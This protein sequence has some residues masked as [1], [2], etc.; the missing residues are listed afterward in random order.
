MSWKMES[1]L[2]MP[3]RKEM[4]PPK[5]DDDAYACEY[6]PLHE[7]VHDGPYVAGPLL[8]VVRG[9]VGPRHRPRD[10]GRAWVEGRVKGDRTRGVRFII[11]PAGEV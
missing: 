3:Q 2:S 6:A 5:R 9:F 1:F 4:R 7:I 10:G 11:R 8:K